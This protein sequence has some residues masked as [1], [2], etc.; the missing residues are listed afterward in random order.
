MSRTGH[1]PFP[2][3]ACISSGSSP[4]DFCAWPPHAGPEPTR[5]LSCCHGN[6]HYAPDAVSHSNVLVPL[7]RPCRLG[8]IRGEV[9]RLLASDPALFVMSPEAKFGPMV[10]FL[11]QELGCGE[12]LLRKLVRAGLLGRRVDTLRV[13]YRIH[14][15]FLVGTMQPRLLGRRVD[16]LRLCFGPGSVAG[17]CGGS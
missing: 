16:T 3:A 14:F 7:A 8:L 10:A 11:R 17:C 6:T 2:H 1:L 12:P 4:I 5:D 9:S 13:G 15:G